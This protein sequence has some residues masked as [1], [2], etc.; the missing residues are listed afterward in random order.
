MKGLNEVGICRILIILQLT[1][2]YINYVGVLRYFA[3]LRI[4]AITNF[5]VRFKTLEGTIEVFSKFLCNG[6]LLR[7]H[8]SPLQVT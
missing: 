5:E 6:G 7:P 2:N 4:E 3:Q 8:Y 1:A